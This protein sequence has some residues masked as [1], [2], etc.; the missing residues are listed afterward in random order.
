MK[1]SRRTGGLVAAGSWMP[2]AALLVPICLAILFLFGN[3]LS[4]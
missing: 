2:G 3:K 1:I 4:A